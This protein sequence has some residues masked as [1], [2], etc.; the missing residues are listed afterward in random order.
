VKRRSGKST[1]R[2]TRHILPFTNAVYYGAGRK[3]ARERPRKNIKGEQIYTV[4]PLY[5]WFFDDAWITVGIFSFGVGK[6]FYDS[7]KAISSSMID[8]KKLSR[9][10]IVS[11][12]TGWVKSG[13]VAALG[14]V[15][16]VA[17]ILLV[18]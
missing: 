16:G 13:S 8:K 11:F 14:V 9:Y 7:G 6:K 5:F 10:C 4:P 1:H 3:Q 2:S 18:V 15:Q 12:V 17:N